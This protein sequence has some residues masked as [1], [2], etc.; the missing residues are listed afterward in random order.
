MQYLVYSFEFERVY[1]SKISKYIAMII[2]T[3]F[4]LNRYHY[5]VTQLSDKCFKISVP[6]FGTSRSA[7][8]IAP[9]VYANVLEGNEIE[10][11]GMDGMAE[12]DLA[13]M[14]TKIKEA[15]GI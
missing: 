11:T 6:T 9:E 7:Y 4:E 15:I 2:H 3:S 13:E 1:L 10:I 8:H 12:K 5:A 14:K